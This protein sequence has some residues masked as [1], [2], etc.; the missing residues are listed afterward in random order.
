MAAS[1]YAVQNCYKNLSDKCTTLG[2]RIGVLDDNYV[3]AGTMTFGVGTQNVMVSTIISKNEVVYSLPFTT[4]YN[5]GARY[6]MTSTTCTYYYK[7]VRSSTGYTMNLIDGAVAPTSS[8]DPSYSGV[9]KS[10]YVVNNKDDL[11]TV[12]FGSLT[13]KPGVYY[14][15]ACSSPT[16]ANRGGTL[17]L[18]SKV[19]N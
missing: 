9:M 19:T 4:S 2:K 16:T 10:T 3:L 15:G 8:T 5:S 12:G 14:Y 1:L 6:F 17:Y 11:D 13:F 7:F 18:Y